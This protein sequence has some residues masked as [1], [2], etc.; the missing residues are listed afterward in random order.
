MKAFVVYYSRTGRTRKVAEAIA[1][2]LSCDKEEIVSTQNL[3]GLVGL[4]RIVYQA[5]R[6]SLIAINDLKRDVAEYDLVIIGTPVWGGTVSLPVKTFIYTC[7]DYFNKVAFFSTH[8]GAESQEE[9]NEMEAV[10]G[11]KPVSVLSF[12]AR[13]VDTDCIED[14]DQFVAELK[15]HES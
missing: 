10:C 15:T 12:S 11:K 6:K 2:A 4:L 14:V 9:F 1:D 7:K 3:S 5:M 13:K 8:G